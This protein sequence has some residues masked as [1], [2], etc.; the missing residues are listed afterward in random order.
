M[1]HQD[2][3]KRGNPLADGNKHR[4]P[5]KP[6]YPHPL[7]SRKFPHLGRHETISAKR[8]EGQVR[9]SLVTPVDNTDRILL[10]PVGQGTDSNVDV[11]HDESSSTHQ[12]SHNIPSIKEEQVVRSPEDSDSF[13]QKKRGHASDLTITEMMNRALENHR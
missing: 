3:E 2:V 4:K 5:G 8:K 11:V 12:S 10:K 7:P 13:K 6:R 9:A 1:T